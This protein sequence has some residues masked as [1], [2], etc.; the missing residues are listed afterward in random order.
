MREK[1]PGRASRAQLL[2]QHRTRVISVR[3]FVAVSVLVAALLVTAVEAGSGAASGE[4][5]ATENQ[6][7]VTHPDE[8]F[9]LSVELKMFASQ[10]EPEDVPRIEPTRS[11]PVQTTRNGGGHKGR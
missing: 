4:I 5:K 2:V 8:R 6:E 3:K 9:E 11:P 10:I 1:A 7:L